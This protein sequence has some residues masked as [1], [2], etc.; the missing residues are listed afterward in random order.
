[1]RVRC[2]ALQAADLIIAT[3]EKW[4]GIS[5]NWQNRA[6]VQ[7]VSLL[8]ID[9]IHLLGGD[10]CAHNAPI[11]GRQLTMYHATTAPAAST[12]AD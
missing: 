8:V 9:E 11:L 6:Y 5:R 3:P 2:R 1:M 7:K 10:R 12:V 4:D